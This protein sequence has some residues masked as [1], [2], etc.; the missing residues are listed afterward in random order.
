MEMSATATQEMLRVRRWRAAM[1][2]TY[3]GSI[4]GKRTWLSV[5]KMRN[6]VAQLFNAYFA[7]SALLA[8]ARPDNELSRL[9]GVGVDVASFSP[10]LYPPVGGTGECCFFV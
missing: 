5:V 7:I 6:A 9:P 4:I 2:R 3:M 10:N 1:L 8:L